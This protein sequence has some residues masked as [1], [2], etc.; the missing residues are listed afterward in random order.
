MVDGYYMPIR[1]SPYDQSNLSAAAKDNAAVFVKN[2]N[3][4][5][6]GFIDNF[7]Y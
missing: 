6:Y 7:Y 1:Y 2:W 3:D 5:N 4:E